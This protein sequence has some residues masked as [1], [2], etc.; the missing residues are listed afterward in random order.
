[1]EYDRFALP[2]CG[3]IEM[4]YCG[5]AISE[6]Y[7]SP[8]IISVSH[9]LSTLFGC[10]RPTPMHNLTMSSSLKELGHN[11]VSSP[12]VVS[13]TQIQFPTS[14]LSPRVGSISTKNSH[15]GHDWHVS[16]EKY[17]LG[18]ILQS[19][20]RAWDMNLGWILGLQLVV[21]RSTLKIF[22]VFNS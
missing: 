1:M 13:K 6:S 4:A 12:Q 21:P 7:I 19:C 14:I 11:A 8:K 15:C 2:D 5:H 10:S 3:W 16:K 9:S 20:G 17:W 18:K 22:F